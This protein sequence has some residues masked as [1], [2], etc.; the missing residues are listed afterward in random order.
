MRKSNTS[1]YFIV[2]EENTK[3]DTCVIRF[4]ETGTVKK[5]VRSNMLAGKVKDAYKKSVYGEGYYGDFDKKPYWKQAK[6]LWQNML[7]R[8]YCE[9]DKKGY[10]GKAFVCERWKCFANFLEDIS[11]LP[12]FDQWLKGQTSGSEK[13][14]LDKD[15]L[16]QGNV[17]YSP[18]LCQFVTESVNKSAGAKNGKPFTKNKK[19]DND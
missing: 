17:F 16:V 7:K 5:C 13:Y 11:N 10:F 12:N 2:L 1:G 6:Q 18:Y 8:C 4:V 14:N 19:M 15:L 3:E 9:K